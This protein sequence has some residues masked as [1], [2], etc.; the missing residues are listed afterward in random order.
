M[1]QILIIR[2]IL[3]MKKN[4]KGFLLNYIS[5]FQN[6]AL[7]SIARFALSGASAFA[8]HGHILEVDKKLIEPQP[9]RV[10]FYCLKN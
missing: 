6:G 8:L 10:I 9:T 3:A 5:I 1:V 2:L 7:K 4:E